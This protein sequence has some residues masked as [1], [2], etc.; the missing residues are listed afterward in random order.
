VLSIGHDQTSAIFSPDLASMTTK[1]VPRGLGVSG[2]CE[3]VLEEENAEQRNK[4]AEQ[5]HKIAELIEA[6]NRA[7][8]VFCQTNGV[9]AANSDPLTPA[10]CYQTGTTADLSV[11]L[12]GEYSSSRLAGAT[13][14]WLTDNSKLDTFGWAQSTLKISCWWKLVPQTHGE[15]R[16][17]VS[18]RETRQETY[19]GGERE[20]MFASESS[21]SCQDQ[22]VPKLRKWWYRR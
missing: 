12:S 22:S 11:L 16:V 6:N 2:S 9:M 13:L 17:F 20:I 7:A 21:T 15:G 8:D 10:S 14:E 19:P 5:K 3:G 18:Q 4:D 1:L